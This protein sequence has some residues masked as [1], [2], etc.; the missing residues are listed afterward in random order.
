[1]NEVSTESMEGQVAPGDA[2]KTWRSRST[3]I[4]LD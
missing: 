1:M 4:K 3:G 2:G